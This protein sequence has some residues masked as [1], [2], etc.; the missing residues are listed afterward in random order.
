MISHKCHYNGDSYVPALCINFNNFVS[1]QYFFCLVLEFHYLDV[2]LHVQFL[3][4]FSDVQ[5]FHEELGTRQIH[6]LWEWYFQAG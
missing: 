6:R 2:H 3:E 5:G 1:N 4:K